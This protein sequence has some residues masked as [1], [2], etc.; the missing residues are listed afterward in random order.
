MT[1]VG[2]LSWNPAQAPPL[3]AARSEK[4]LTARLRFYEMSHPGGASTVA[5][6]DGDDIV[7]QVGIK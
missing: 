7:T 4:E 2:D 1:T 6:P 5:R 3:A